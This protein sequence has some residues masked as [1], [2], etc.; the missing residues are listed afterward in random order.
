MFFKNLLIYRLTEPFNYSAESLH[1]QL[2]THAYKPCYKTESFS[3]GW[4]SPY[5]GNHSMLVHSIK[6]YM[7]FAFCKEEKLIPNTVIKDMLEQK[8]IEIEQREGRPVYRKEKVELKE[9]I[10]HD[11]RQ[12][13]FSRKKITFAYID[14]QLNWLLVDTASRKKAEEICCHLRKTLG[15]LKLELPSTNTAPPLIMTSWL[16]NK[17]QPASFHIANDCD[18]LDE[19]QRI[20]MIKCKEQDLNAD[21]IIRHLHNGKQVIKLALSWENKIK[22]DLCDD[23]TIKKIRFLDLIEKS[24]LKD[25]SPEEQ[26]DGHFAIMSGEFAQFLPDLWSLFDGLASLN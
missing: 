1:E 19:K 2:E 6:G 24:D 9:Q 3:L 13:A 20:G 8:M 23:L 12:K 26:L 16:I 4:V 17:K 14:T 18:M 7:L 22:F 10:L 25:Q 15:S 21:E 11:L 5:G